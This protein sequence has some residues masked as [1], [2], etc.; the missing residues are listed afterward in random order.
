[1]TQFDRFTEKSRDAIQ[2]AAS[3]ASQRGQQA[4]EPEHCRRLR[5]FEKAGQPVAAAAG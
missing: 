3:E 2:L 5:V 1:M 4:V